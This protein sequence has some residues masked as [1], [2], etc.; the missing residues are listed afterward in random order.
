[1]M[2]GLIAILIGFI[3]YLLIPK[4]RIDMIY[5]EENITIE[6]VMKN[7]YIKEIKILPK[8]LMAS[9][10]IVLSKDSIDNIVNLMK[11]KIDDKNIKGM[12][13]EIKNEKIK[14]YVPYKLINLIDTQIELDAIPKIDYNNLVIRIDNVKIGKLKINNEIVGKNN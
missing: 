6:Q 3:Y 5:K 2:V 1:M 14:I 13:A 8:G 9:A 10:E 12:D 4:N 11:N 7:S